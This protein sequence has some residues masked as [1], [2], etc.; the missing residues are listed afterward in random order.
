MDTIKLNS[1]HK[2]PYRGI[3]CYGLREPFPIKPTD[4]LICCDLRNCNFNGLDLSMVEFFGCRLNGTSFQGAT[5]RETKLIGCFSADNLQPTDF[6]NSIWQEVSVVDSYL[7]HLS[8]N[9]LSDALLWSAEA[10]VAATET[11][12]ERND[13][14]YEAA[15]KLGDLDNP[16]VAPILACLLADK[17]WD[18]RSIALE[19]LGKLLHEQFPYGV[20]ALLEWIFLSLGDS[21]SIVRQTAIELVETLSPSDDVLLPSIQRIMANSSKESLEG[22]RAAIELC[23]LDDR[24]SRLLDRKTLQLLLSDEVPEIRSKSAY[25]L[26]ILN[27]QTTRKG[28]DIDLVGFAKQSLIEIP[29]NMKVNEFRETSKNKLK[30]NKHI[31]MAS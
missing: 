18:V 27:E 10:V 3:N 4:S 22:L 30:P 6:R 28:K 25:L 11:L 9:N 7:N 19:V 12:S 23:E 2:N 13:V 16:V 14:R 21:H 26:E 8:D 20:Q 1:K 24:Y 31:S 29:H 17:E 15:T 5:L